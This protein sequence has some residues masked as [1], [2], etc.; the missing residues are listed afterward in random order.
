MN[1]TNKKSPATTRAV[2]PKAAAGAVNRKPPVAPPVYRPQPVPK[3]L[4]TKRSPLQNLPASKAIAGPPQHR[5][6]IA[7]PMMATLTKFRPGSVVQRMEQRELSSDSDEESGEVDIRGFCNYNTIKVDD[8][9]NDEKA[10]IKHCFTYCGSAQKL[11]WVKFAF[12]VGAPP[13]ELGH[14]SELAQPTGNKK[15]KGGGGK[16]SGTGK[17]EV[18]WTKFQQAMERILAKIDP[19]GKGTPIQRAERIVKRYDGSTPKWW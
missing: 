6:R 18:R 16:K 15:T 8:A 11:T 1:S 9:W 10:M 12:I 13:P 5:S 7:Q 3:V 14:G 17:D 19:D 2:Q 4:Q